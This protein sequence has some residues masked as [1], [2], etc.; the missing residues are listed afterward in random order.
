MARYCVCGCGQELK[1]KSGNTD[2]ER[3]FFDRTCRNRDKA[4]RMRDQRARM[5]K[6]KRCSKCGSLIK[7]K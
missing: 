7:K 2:Y 3:V 6:Q 5:N 4:Q 1:D